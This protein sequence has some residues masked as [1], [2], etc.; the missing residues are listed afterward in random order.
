M[1]CRAQRSTCFREYQPAAAASGCWEQRKE[2]Q[3][4]YT[5]LISIGFLSGV[6]STVSDGE[7]YTVTSLC[8]IAYSTQHFIVCNIAKAKFVPSDSVLIAV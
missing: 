3:A 5:A 7:V 4:P 8:P 1:K 2:Q 6:D